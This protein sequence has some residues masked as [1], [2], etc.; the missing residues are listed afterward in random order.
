M[1]FTIGYV[2][3]DTFLDVVVRGIGM[4]MV[5]GYVSTLLSY[6][7]MF[8]FELLVAPCVTG[9]GLVKVS[10]TIMTVLGM[11]I[12]IVHMLLAGS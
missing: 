8:K 1:H 5:E 6:S 12:N 2:R 3:D 10:R 7:M 4:G 11:G 9:L